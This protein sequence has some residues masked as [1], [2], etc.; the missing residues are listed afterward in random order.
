M[1]VRVLN[2]KNRKCIIFSSFFLQISLNLHITALIR[3]KNKP[4]IFFRYFNALVPLLVTIPLIFYDLLLF[5][6]IKKFS[7]S[8][9]QTRRKKDQ[10]GAHKIIWHLNFFAHLR[11]AKE[12]RSIFS[13]DRIRLHNFLNAHTSWPKLKTLKRLHVFIL[14]Y[15]FTKLPQT[16]IF[17]LLL[18][19]RAK[20]AR[21]R[22]KK[23]EFKS[24][25][26]KPHEEEKWW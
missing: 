4:Q 23:I 7:P 5:W 20:I 1:K 15:H 12:M 22:A 18:R 17:L 9:C 6:V 24:F 25:W 13:S 26:V 16:K 19:S 11:R 21:E 2:F 14:F 8:E 3:R 10:S